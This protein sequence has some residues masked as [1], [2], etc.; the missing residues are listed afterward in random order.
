[1][2]KFT[3]SDAECLIFTFKDGLLS[4]IAHDLKIRVT[5]FEVDV[6]EEPR[7]VSARFDLGSL[8]VIDAQKNGE[9]N[10]SALSESDKSK[11]A[12]QISADVLHASQHGQAQFQSTSV[13]PNPDGGFLV[14]GELSLHG[15]TKTLSVQTK[16]LNGS[17]VAE[18]SLH[19]PDYGIT[20]YKAMMGTL[21]VKPAVLIRLTVPE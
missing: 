10:P 16:P 15:V 21:K 5:Q 9:D 13:E 14:V 18:F 11:I 4:K 6:S 7:T 20:P 8:Q 19:Q 3:A 12:K 2:S 1:M 17:Q